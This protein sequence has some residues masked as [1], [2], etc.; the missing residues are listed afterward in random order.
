MNKKSDLSLSTIHSSESRQ[1]KD[2]AMASHFSDVIDYRSKM[3]GLDVT[4]DV[5]KDTMNEIDRMG[6]GER[7]GWRRRRGDHC[8]DLI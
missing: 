8:L 4:D 5:Q 7:D 6:N 1:N 2:S 3:S